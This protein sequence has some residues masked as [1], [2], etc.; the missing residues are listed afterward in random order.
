MNVLFVCKWNRF[1]SKAA[2]ALFKKLNKNP[3]FK[4]KS[5]GLFP[6]VPVT[7]DIIEAGKNIGVNISMTQQG[8]PHKLLMWSDYI[9]L[10]ADDVPKSIFNDVVKND[11]KKVLHW[12]LKDIQ[13]TDIKKR[14][15]IMLQI[16][17]NVVKF[18]KKHSDD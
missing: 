18:L 1:R 13:G 3:S 8:L 17:D 6:G 15:Q 14:E 16:R 7:N 4:V 10:V 2:E 5:G 9:I 12:K 11:G